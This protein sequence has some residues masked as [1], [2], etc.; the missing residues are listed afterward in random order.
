MSSY[1]TESRYKEYRCDSIENENPTE[2][3]RDDTNS[4]SQQRQQRRRR[5]QIGGAA[6]VGG[7][8]GLCCIGPVF[9][10]VAASGAAAVAA[11]TKKGHAMGDVVRSTGEVAAHTGDKLQQFNRQHRIVEKTSHTIVQGCRWVTHQWK[12]K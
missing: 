11:T 1:S 5:R 12:D 9:G 8:V 7:I 2:E 4:T 6:A 10:I 3:E